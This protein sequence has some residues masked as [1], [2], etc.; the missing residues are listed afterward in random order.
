[1]NC[2]DGKDVH[3]QS[4]QTYFQS[5]QTSPVLLLHFRFKAVAKLLIKSGADV[6]IQGNNGCTAFDMASIIGECKKYFLILVDKVVSPN[7]VLPTG[8]DASPL[9]GYL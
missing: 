6:N 7:I 4:V 1:M 2:V 8:R 3:F 9:Q 5:V